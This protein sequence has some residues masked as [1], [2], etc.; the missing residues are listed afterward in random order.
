VAIRSVTARPLDPATR[1]AIDLLE[2]ASEARLRLRV[3]Y[4]DER[5]AETRRILRP[6]GLWFW[7]NVWTLVAWCELRQG[8]RMFRVDRMDGPEVLDRFT[9]EPG[10]RIEDFY[11]A[12]LD[13]RCD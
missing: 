7:G 3:T 9:P 8:F 1:A 10:Q 5:G 6:L 11:A 13:R 12:E 4:R 2:H